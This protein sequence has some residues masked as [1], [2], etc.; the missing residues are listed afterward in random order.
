MVIDRTAK[1]TPVRVSRVLMPSSEARESVRVHVIILDEVFMIH[2]QWFHGRT[3]P[4][5]AARVVAVGLDARCFAGAGRDHLN[6]VPAD[7][8]TRQRS[9]YAAPRT[10]WTPGPADPGRA[11]A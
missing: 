9:R 5:T 1:P 4:R 8:R 3:T 2:E 7:L 6:R 10:R 11:P